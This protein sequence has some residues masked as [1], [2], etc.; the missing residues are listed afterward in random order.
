MAGYKG[1]GAAAPIEH[2]LEPASVGGL[3]F[4]DY[5]ID[6]GQINVSN[7]CAVQVTAMRCRGQKSSKGSKGNPGAR[8][9]ASNTMPRWLHPVVLTSF[10]SQAPSTSSPLSTPAE[11]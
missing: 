6:R 8:K 1:Q 4:E 9:P 3:Q 11:I 7:L 2:Q 5:L 10:T